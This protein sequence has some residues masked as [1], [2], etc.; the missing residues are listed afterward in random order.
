MRNKTYSIK[1]MV[2]KETYDNFI[3][4]CKDLG[5]SMTLFIEKVANEPVVFLDKN[6]KL[7][8]KNLE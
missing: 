7:L 8:L 2:D 3:N 5:I 6:A 1:A 4:K